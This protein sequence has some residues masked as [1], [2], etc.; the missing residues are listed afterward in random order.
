VRVEWASE[1]PIEVDG[2]PV[3]RRR[4]VEMAVLAQAFEL[5]V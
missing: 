2:H 5:L 4:V 3:G 1:Q